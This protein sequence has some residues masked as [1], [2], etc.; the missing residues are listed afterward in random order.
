[1]YLHPPS[2]RS[3]MSPSDQI[4]SAKLF[5]FL[6]NS[7]YSKR[8]RPL[9]VYQS[10]PSPPRLP[11]LP[12]PPILSIPT[13]HLPLQKESTIYITIFHKDQKPQQS[14]RRKRT[15][16]GGSYGCIYLDYAYWYVLY[17]RREPPALELLGKAGGGFGS[18]VGRDFFK[19]CKSLLCFPRCG[20]GTEVHTMR[21]RYGTWDTRSQQRAGLMLS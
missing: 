4:R 15:G 3:L 18:K 6:N 13:H 14:P 16:S 19:S 1:M 7:Y 8:P 9:P 10:S 12:S 11:T 17:G 2:R 21:V 20:K 5:F